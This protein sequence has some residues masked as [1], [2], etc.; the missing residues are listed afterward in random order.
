MLQATQAA[1]ELI[2]LLSLNIPAHCRR[3]VGRNTQLRKVNINIYAMARDGL[4]EALTGV[5][6]RALQDTQ[7]VRLDNLQI[8]TNGG[9]QAVNVT[10]TGLQKPEALRGRVLIVF[11][12]VAAQRP[13]R[14][15]RNG[16]TTPA[17]SAL[18]LE[19]QQTLEDLQHTREL[20]QVTHEEMQTSVEELKSS[21]EELQSTNEEL[22]SNNE[23]VTTSR[24]ELQSL[25][26]ELQTVNAEL[27]SKVDELTL[28]K[29]DMSNLL[30]ST[31]IATIFLDGEMQIR[32]FTP[33]ATRLFKLIP[34]DVGRA[35][36]D[37][38]SKLDYPTLLQD[39]EDVLR[40]LIY[41]EKHMRTQEGGNFRVRIMPYRTQ[42]NVIDGVVITF[43]D[44]GPPAGRAAQIDLPV[45]NGGQHP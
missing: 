38:V 21:N 20:L 28:V 5:I 17:A 31:E 42:D 41:R 23:E 43:I 24:E 16:E 1:V 3:Q 7:P 39:A 11:N 44:L 2:K 34:G 15:L 35:L 30:N 14:R 25:T 4:R 19:L 12:D 6:R 33:H 26:E 10:V 27:Q 29:N 8:G 9:T 13:A 40:T 22:Q 18:A 37:I 36:S 45:A 32:S